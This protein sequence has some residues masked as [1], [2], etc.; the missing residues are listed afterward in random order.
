MKQGKAPFIPVEQLP[1]VLA[2]CEG[3]HEKR[4]QALVLVSHFLGLRAKEMAA[5]R[6]SDVV[7]NGQ[8]VDTIRL[9]R[10]MTK[11]AKF[12]EAYLVNADTRQIILEYLQ[13]RN[14]PNLDAP[15]F[16]SRKGGHFSANS[17]Q[18]Q[19]ARIYAKS[20]IK[21]SSHSGR[22]SFATRL[23][24]GGADIYSIKELMGHTSIA[25]TQIYFFTSPE[26]LKTVVSLLG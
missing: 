11:G 14:E 26:R 16:L 23:I 10:S 13:E 18:R 8:L 4:D 21:A 1:Y 9:L 12:R 2:A 17:M 6:I 22:R 20:G 5:L 15:L 3:Q 24:Q 25:T 19:M 7:Q